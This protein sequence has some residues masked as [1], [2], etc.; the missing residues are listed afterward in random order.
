MIMNV[1]I[2]V[3]YWPPGQNL[4]QCQQMTGANKF[5]LPNRIWG[6]ISSSNIIQIMDGWEADILII[7]LD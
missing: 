6:S 5:H 2:E 7:Y 1:Q 4:Q 3:T